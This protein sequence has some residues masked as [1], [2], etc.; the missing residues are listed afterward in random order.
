MRAFVLPESSPVVLSKIAAVINNARDDAA[1]GPHMLPLLK[2]LKQHRDMILAFNYKD[3]ARA[4]VLHQMFRDLIAPTGTS[5]RA[6][7]STFMDKY[8]KELRIASMTRL[9]V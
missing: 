3:G 2:Y 1:R 5:A 7:W 8:V 6:K 9:H 4:A